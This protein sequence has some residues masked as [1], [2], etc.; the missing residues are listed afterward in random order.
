MKKILIT[1]ATSSLL[2]A[3]VSSTA[4]AQDD[5]AE[6]VVPVQLYACN[7]NDGMGPAD[8]DT[9]TANWNAWA[10]GAGLKDYTAWTLEKYYFGP[11][12]TFDVLWL[13]VAPNG[14]AMGRGHDMYQATGGEAAMG[15]AKVIN[16]DSH[17]RFAAMEFKAPPDGDPAPSIVLAFQDCKIA[18]GKNFKDNVAPGVRKW[19]DF[20]RAH[21]SIGGQ[22][23]LFPAYGGGGEEFD[24]KWVSSHANHEA[25]G[26]NWDS[27]DGELDSS[28]F[29][30]V[31]DCDS[32]RVYNATS[33]RM[34][35]AD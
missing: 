17:S 11:L 26:Q 15:F 22:W 8:F 27:Y 33:R 19:A 6:T 25:M 4:L 10:D 7:Y 32:S 18:K 34:A 21:G 35:E 23:I 24:F 13:G 14:T 28:L 30:G 3:A 2:M 1:L 29:D 12:Q 31:I 9:A 16:C 5:G 20:R